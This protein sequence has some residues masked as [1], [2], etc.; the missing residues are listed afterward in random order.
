MGSFVIES[1]NPPRPGASYEHYRC[2]T[3]IEK[4][5]RWLR[6]KGVTTE[7]PLHTLR[8]EYGS[9]ISR[10]GRHLR[11]EPGTPVR[12]GNITITALPG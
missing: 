8:K 7:T 6:A 12:H 1:P 4:L 10:A 9:Q 5:L 2:Q 11:R 3:L